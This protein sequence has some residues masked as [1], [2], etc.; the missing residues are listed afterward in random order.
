MP[1]FASKKRLNLSTRISYKRAPT[2]ITDS[3]FV[4][5]ADAVSITAG[6]TLGNIHLRLLYSDGLPATA[7]VSASFQSLS[8][9]LRA[10][11][12]SQGFTTMRTFHFCSSSA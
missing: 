9:A 4:D 12:G 11:D 10:N 3:L 6:D 1:S 7:A 8:A 5:R 2:N